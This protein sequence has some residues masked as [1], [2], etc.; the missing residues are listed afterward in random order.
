MKPLFSPKLDLKGVR[1]NNGKILVF[2]WNIAK[3]CM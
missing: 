3:F 1:R 2:Y